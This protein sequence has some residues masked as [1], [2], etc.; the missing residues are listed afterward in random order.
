MLKH[1]DING[2]TGGG[3]VLVSSQDKGLQGVVT[4]KTVIL[5]LFQGLA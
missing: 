1:T 4:A 5:N 3:G 2:F